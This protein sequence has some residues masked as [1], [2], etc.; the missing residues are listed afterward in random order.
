MM[1]DPLLVAFAQH[2]SSTGGE[3]PL[4][5]LVG[6]QLVSGVLVSEE[7]WH[8]EMAA[9]FDD[10]PASAVVEGLGRQFREWRAAAVLEGV[11]AGEVDHLHLV[12]AQVAGT[13][14]LGRWRVRV[15]A[16]DGWRLG[17]MPLPVEGGAV[18]GVVS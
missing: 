10:A 9:A 3:W 4:T 16:V 1:P 6:G 7:R 2:A 11:E 12:G 14:R 17:R 5:L 13:A 15:S 8:A 18:E